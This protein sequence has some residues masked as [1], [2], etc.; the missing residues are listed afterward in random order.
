[1]RAPLVTLVVMLAFGPGAG[2]SRAADYRLE[3]TI[4]S[5]EDTRQFTYTATISRMDA[6]DL[7]QSGDRA[8]QKYVIDAKKAYAQRKG[9]TEPLYGPDFWKMVRVDGWD[10]VVVDPD[11]HRTVASGGKGKIGQGF[12]TGF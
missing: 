12:S 1:M 2:L 7:A 4:R 5:N 9:Y 6:S 10:W 3:M 8:V 11:T